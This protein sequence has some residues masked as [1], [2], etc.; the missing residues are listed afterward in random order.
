MNKEKSKWKKKD[1]TVRGLSLW[2]E[3]PRFPEEYFTKSEPELIEYF[4]RKKEFKIESF[5]KEVA[6]EFDLPQLEKIVVFQYKGKNIV[7]EGNRRLIIYKLLLNPSLTN[8]QS[9]RNL[10]E[11]LQKQTR[12]KK[13]FKLE[14][15]VTSVK[16]EGLR[17]VDR[18]HNRGNNEVGWGEPERRNFATR[19]SHG[20]GKDVLR[21][22]LANAVKKLSLPDALKEAVLSR[23][24]VTTFY[25]IADSLVARKK[26][27]YEVS[28]SGTI[29]IGDQRRFDDLLK[30]IVYN[31]WA[32]KDFRGGDVDSRT[33]N[34]TKSIGDY[35][36]GLQIKDANRVDK[37][38]KKSTKETLFGEQVILTPSRTRSNQLSDSRK[39]LINS[40]IYIQSSRINDIYD[41]LR[42]KIEVNN[43]PNAVAVLFRVFMEC[44]ID[45]YIDAN[46]LMIKEDTKLA[47]KIL[48]VVD[49]LED[50]IALRRLAE[51]GKKTPTPEEFKKVKEKV[52]F[53]NIRKVATRDNNSILSVETFHEF[54]HDYKTSP[55]PSE[56]KKHWENLD[57]FF[58]A[59]WNSFITIKKKKNK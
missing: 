46:K 26:L 15:N 17:F 31:V 14:A 34:K 38:I 49:H 6:K 52:K 2:D 24:L 27:G 16:D 18:K 1:L 20:K 5:A 10:F 55:I 59:L 56:L 28:E 32:K 19:R 22:E 54:V 37:E 58:G 8:D 13:S 12:I 51:E 40:S 7:L 35:I 41:E 29:G 53:K 42:K 45:Y 47:G 48:K 25:R 39:Y 30:V 21:V 3:N 11:N 44:S 50:A 33:L 36:S 4:L 43:A 9:L 23:G 57:S